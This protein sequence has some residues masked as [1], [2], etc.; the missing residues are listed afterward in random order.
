MLIYCIYKYNIENKVVLA[1]YLVG[2]AANKYNTID[3]KIAHF[4]L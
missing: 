2:I 1:E 3:N 4:V